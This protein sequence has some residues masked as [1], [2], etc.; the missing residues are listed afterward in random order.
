[1]KPDNL[2]SRP[3]FDIGTDGYHTPPGLCAALCETVRALGHG[4]KVNTPYGGA[5]VPMKFYRQEK[6]VISVMF[7]ANRKLYMNEKTM[8][9]TSGFPATRKVCH[10]LMRTAAQFVEENWRDKFVEENWRGS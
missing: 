5:M 4:V 2:I 3:D 6:N 8:T 7:E 1:M 9:K 10:E